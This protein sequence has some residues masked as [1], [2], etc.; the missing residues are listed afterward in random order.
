MAERVVPLGDVEIWSEELGDPAGP[1]LLLIMGAAASAM[2][3]PD[4]LVGLLTAGGHRVIRYDHRDTGRSTRRDFAA[5]PYPFIAFVRDAVGVLD[6]YGV[7]SAH[8][9]GASMGG[10]IGQLLALGHPDRVRTLT[11]M[12][13]TALDVFFS[14]D[15]SGLPEPDPRVLKVLAAGIAGPAADRDA[16]IDKR[17]AMWR[18]LAGEALP[19]DPEEFR[20][21]EERVIDH[22][23]DLTPV[24]A[25][26]QVTE[27]PAVT[28]ADLRAITTPTLV[29]QGTHDPFFPPPHGQRLAE[30]IPG[31]R[32]L[33][34]PGMGHALPKV[35]HH[36]IAE[37][38]LAHTR[39][40]P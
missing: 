30:A 39:P 15:A 29:I 3:W 12:M 16:E 6:A 33:E 26:A 38:I 7:A 17:V 31:A 2:G 19:F 9:V 40:R 22:A 14:G 5:H 18:A 4:G 36:R 11:V 32:L 23:G 24:K 8:V 34:I 13:T 27:T 28:A 25:H 20:R 35:V 37:A 21:L 1:P 10:A